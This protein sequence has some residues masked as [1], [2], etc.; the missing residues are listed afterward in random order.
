MYFFS[1]LFHFHA[2]F[3]ARQLGPIQ[4]EMLPSYIFLSLGHILPYTLHTTHYSTDYTLH[5]THYTHYTIVAS[6]LEVVCDKEEVG[7]QEPTL[8]FLLEILAGM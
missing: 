5:T 6:F 1:V 7:S 2:F 8:H 4:I 3:L